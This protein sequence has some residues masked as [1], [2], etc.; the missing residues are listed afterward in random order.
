MQACEKQSEAAEAQLLTL[1]PDVDDH[2]GAG[3]SPPAET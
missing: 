2:A 3:Q 1:L